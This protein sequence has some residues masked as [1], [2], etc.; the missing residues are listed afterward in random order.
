LRMSRRLSTLLRALPALAVA[1][2]ATAVVI[3][4]ADAASST[5]SQTIRFANRATVRV[6]LAA[7]APYDFGP[8]DPL[9]PRDPAGDENTATVWSN[10]SWRLFVRAAGP[11]FVEVP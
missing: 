1:L 8:V 6:Q 2:L 10:A 9:A 7:T 4:P 3:G 11:A 5:G